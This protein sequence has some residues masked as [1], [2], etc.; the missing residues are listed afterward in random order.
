MWMWQ[1]GWEIIVL[2]HN[3]MEKPYQ[4]WM[5]VMEIEF[6]LE[7]ISVNVIQNILEIN[8]KRIDHIVCKYCWYSIVEFFVS[9]NNI[10]FSIF[11][12]K[13]IHIY[14]YHF[15]SIFKK[16]IFKNACYILNCH[17][18]LNLNV[19]GFKQIEQHS[20]I[21]ILPVICVTKLAKIHSHV[22]QAYL[23]LKMKEQ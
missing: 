12:I 3:V 2:Y 18:N 15:Y 22:I 8:V 19:I 16:C 11:I 21:Q 1:V 4:I 17:K 14:R 6:V 20:F 5:Y 13:V 23:C 10:G 7:R 9:C